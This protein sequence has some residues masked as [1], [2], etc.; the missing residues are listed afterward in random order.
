MR[1]RALGATAF[2]SSSARFD[3]SMKIIDWGDPG[4]PSPGSPSRRG[5]GGD[6]AALAGSISP[7]NQHDQPSVITTR[8]GLL[9]VHGNIEHGPSAGT[10][11]VES[12][13]ASEPRHVGGEK[14]VDTQRRRVMLPGYARPP[15]KRAPWKSMAFD[16]VHS[17]VQQRGPSQADLHS[18]RM[19]GRLQSTPRLARTAQR[20]RIVDSAV[21]GELPA[22]NMR[23]TSAATHRAM[24]IYHTDPETTVV[25]LP[26]P[27]ADQV[28]GG[29]QQVRVR[30]AGAHT[31]RIVLKQGGTNSIGITAAGIWKHGRLGSMTALT[32]SFIDG[33]FES[34]YD[35][36]APAPNKQQMDIL[37][38]IQ[39]VERV[40]IHD[41]NSAPKSAWS[42]SKQPAS[43]VGLVSRP[44]TI[45]L[46]EE[47]Q[48]RMHQSIA[49]NISEAVSGFKPA[50]GK[51]RKALQP[52]CQTL[53]DAID[54]SQP[55]KVPARLTDRPSTVERLA[56]RTPACD[57]MY[58]LP[59][60]FSSKGNNLQRSTVRAFARSP[61]VS[62][63]VQRDVLSSTDEAVAS[64]Q[65]QKGTL[66]QGIGKG[67]ARM[68]LDLVDVQ[69]PDTVTVLCDLQQM[70]EQGVPSQPHARVDYD[71]QLKCDGRVHA[72]RRIECNQGSRHFLQVSRLIPG[73]HSF[74]T[75]LRAVNN[76]KWL[77]WGDLLVVNVGL[78]TKDHSEPGWQKRGCSEDFARVSSLEFVERE[79]SRLRLGSSSV[80]MVANEPSSTASGMPIHSILA[81]KSR[82]TESS[83][84]VP[85]IDPSVAVDAVSE[86][87]VA[88]DSPG[89]V[90][91]WGRDVK[92][93]N[94]DHHLPQLSQHS[95]T[96]VG[97]S[98][99]SLVPYSGATGE[100]DGSFGVVNSPN[101][102]ELG[103]FVSPR[104]REGQQMW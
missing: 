19:E 97:S 46:G 13:G 52:N 34:L 99:S 37:V 104:G 77:P 75:R 59:S 102:V 90:D 36:S 12:P 88:S 17:A 87:E 9:H 92:E 38:K 23:K 89:R 71:M 74:Q 60:E 49:Q 66:I 20:R 15:Q 3:P 79:L 95:L 70:D 2:G 7:V 30:T 93:S 43:S 73:I 51:G 27:R 32:D 61:R 63:C 55:A 76:S 72:Q 100:E 96:S 25:S 1:T 57:Q 29:I 84:R 81:E 82:Q 26:S 54:F 22:R 64:G 8:D 86:W 16:G 62:K 47:A 103:V 31:S 44:G 41:G 53:S 50:G 11:T 69:H 68:N 39:P 10:R 4:G 42:P 5:G 58:D 18:L 21:Q 98:H 101:V 6:M 56:I 14:C 91:S 45:R 94:S 35:A 80:V 48:A 24:G 67:K 78:E 83:Q 28:P 85:S 40:E 65:M 33:N